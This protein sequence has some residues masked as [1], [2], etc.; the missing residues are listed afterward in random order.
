MGNANEILSSRGKLNNLMEDSPF[1][2]YTEIITALDSEK[3][4][5]AFQ[6]TSTILKLDTSNGI[7]YYIRHGIATVG[8]SRDEISKSMCKFWLDSM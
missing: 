1:K 3:G 7:L 2:G 6:G 5:P 4:H 8:A